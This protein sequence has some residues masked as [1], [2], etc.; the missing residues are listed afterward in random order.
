MAEM[1]LANTEAM[2]QGMKQPITNINEANK[3]LREVYI[4]KHNKKFA[5]LPVSDTNMHRELREEERDTLETIFSIHS[6]RT[7]MNDYTISF[8]NQLYQLHAG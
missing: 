1:K 2:R 5:V 4:P 8:Q 6:T 7:I 3:F